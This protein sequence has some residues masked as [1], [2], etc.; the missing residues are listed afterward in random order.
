MIKIKKIFFVILIF[1]SFSLKA[2]T[3]IQDSIYITIGKK[4]VTKSDI[5]NEIKVILILNNESYSEEKRDRLQEIAIKS[6]VER[7]IKEIEIEKNNFLTFNKN[8]L[9]DE[10]TKLANRI[11]VDLDTLKNICAS[12]ELDFSIIERKVATELLWNSLIFQLYKDRLTINVEEIDDQLRLLQ[13]KKE[14]NEFL[15]SEIV[16]NPVNETDVEEEINNIKNRIKTEG[17]DK[18]AMD[19]S[20]SETAS[21]GGDLGWVKENVISAKYIS[22][23]SKTPIGTISD[24]IFL[25]EGILIFK[26]KDKRKIEK[27]LTLEQQKDQL[28]YAE[29][30]KI[31]K[32]HSLSHY[33][34]LRRA[35]PIKFFNE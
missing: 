32:M 3:A 24:P 31:L 5:V 9:T 13:N 7:T 6:T 22:Q 15:I 18:V 25:P 20:I 11:N 30:T 12:N 17:F 21:K 35:T 29:K 8:D 27:N 1:L 28:V 23:I 14:L 19:I 4:A 34:K 16:I 10:L 26:V 33:D 2:N